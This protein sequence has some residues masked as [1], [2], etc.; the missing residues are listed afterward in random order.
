[1]HEAQ[2][3]YD[4]YWSRSGST[5]L[6]NRILNFSLLLSVQ[7]VPLLEGL[8]FFVEVREG[9]DNRTRSI[10][11]SLRELGANISETITRHVTHVIFLNGTRAN[12]EKAKKRGL[13]IL[14]ILWIIACK[15]AGKL[16]PW[17]PY[18]SSSLE[19]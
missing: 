11:A 10:Q 1:M 2:N 19:K 6:L 12:F 7:A 4:S 18:P 16:V 3:T 14:S 8:T 5:T 13:P 15:E 17:D 9:R